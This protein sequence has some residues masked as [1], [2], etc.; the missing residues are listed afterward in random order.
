MNSHFNLVE[1]RNTVGGPEHCDEAQ[2]RRN[3]LPSI[4]N[5]REQP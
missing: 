4:I 3:R 5:H 1:I 2:L